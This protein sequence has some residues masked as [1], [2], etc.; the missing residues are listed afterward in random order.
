MGLISESAF[1]SMFNEARDNLVSCLLGTWL[2]GGVGGDL[3]L[4][5]GD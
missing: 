4:R 1:W 5:G 2:K 3:F